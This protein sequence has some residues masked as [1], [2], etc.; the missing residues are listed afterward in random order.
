MQ[1]EEKVCVIEPPTT[2]KFIQRSS[3]LQQLNVKDQG[4]IGRDLRRRALF[5]VGGTRWDDQPPLAAL[6]HALD[7][8]VPAW[9]V[10]SGRVKS[11]AR[12]RPAHSNAPGNHLLAAESEAEG[13]L[14]RLVK[15]LAILQLAC[16]AGGNEKAAT[17]NTSTRTDVVDGDLAVNLGLLPAADE[18]VNGG[19]ACDGGGAGDDFLFGKEILNSAHL[20][21]ASFLLA[22]SAAAAAAVAVDQLVPS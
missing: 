19:H 5:A 14:A 16:G 18:R 7:A 20:A 11:A 22:C 3:H 15:D 1:G 17:I 9:G 21:P 10:G 2:K 12:S 6:S 13:L 8:N 4:G